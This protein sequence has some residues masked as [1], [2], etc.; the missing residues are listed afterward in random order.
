MSRSKFKSA[1]EVVL[2]F[3][4]SLSR[5]QPI[6]QIARGGM[7]EVILAEMSVGRGLVRLAVLKRIWSQFATDQEFVAMFLREARLSAGMNHPN[8]V[9]T[10]EVLGD[11]PRPAIS[12]EYLDGQPLTRVLNRLVGSRSMSWPLKLR[13][14]ANVLAALDYAHELTNPAGGSDGVVHRDVNPQNVFVT[15]SGRVKLIDFGVAKSL[16]GP[17]QTRPGAVKGKLAYMAPE[18]LLG[19]PVDRRADLFAVGVMLW[20]MAAERRLWLGMSE[21]TIM[22]HLGARVPIRPLPTTNGLPPGLAQ[23]CSRA[24]SLEPSRRYATA[25]EFSSDLEKLIPGSDDSLGRQLGK[26]VSLAFAEE[27]AAREALIASH[28]RRPRPVLAEADPQ[29]EDDEVE[30]IAVARATPGAMWTL[31]ETDEP[32]DDDGHASEDDEN[33]TMGVPTEP[34]GSLTVRVVPTPS[35]PIRDFLRAR[36]SR[37]VWGGVGFVA[38]LLLVVVV[39][40]TVSGLR[41]GSTGLNRPPDLAPAGADHAIAAQRAAQQIVIAPMPASAAPAV[42]AWDGTGS[43][44]RPEAPRAARGSQ[45]KSRRREDLDRLWKWLREQP[46][47]P[48]LRPP[49]SAGSAQGDDDVLAPSIDLQSAIPPRQTNPPREQRVRPTGPVDPLDR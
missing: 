12:M 45:Q 40:A 30:V 47:P 13:I 36:S 42:S 5:Y 32:S 9:Q 41:A 21:A 43:V 23:I 18:Q 46:M 25:A 20:E 44:G 15:Y 28:R 22:R 16:S 38:A 11:G 17:Y 27:R 3:P 1:P 8:I 39:S 37:L 29:A 24:L 26:V 48:E 34:S 31:D 6:A 10:F 33:I 19:R 7:A 2:A 49:G 35:S 14:L 4:R